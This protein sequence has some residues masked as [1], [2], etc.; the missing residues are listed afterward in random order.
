MVEIEKQKRKKKIDFAL[1][2]K[3]DTFFHKGGHNYQKISEI[4]IKKGVKQIK[5]GLKVTKKTGFARHN[6]GIYHK[7]NKQN[8]KYQEPWY[9]LTSLSS[10]E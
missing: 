3:Q 6:L 10:V 7:K 4:E 8:K 9:I 1:R 2:Q 5:M